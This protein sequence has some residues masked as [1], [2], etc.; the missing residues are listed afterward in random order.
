MNVFTRS[1]TD[2]LASL[3]KEIDT[4]VGKNQAKQAAA[5]VVL[6]SS[7]PDGDEPKVKEF[8][9]KHG[10]KNVPLTIFD[11][12]AGPPSYKVGKEAEVTVLLWKQQK[13]KANHAF[14]KDGLN[15]DTVQQVVADTEKIL[16]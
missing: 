9:K 16:N 6:L 5:F 8:A 13:V 3:V 2:N 4:F 12:E 10:I 11:G 7:D 1:L 15:K 14:A